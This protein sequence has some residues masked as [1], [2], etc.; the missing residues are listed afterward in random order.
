M[1]EGLTAEKIAVA[2]TAMEA[3]KADIDLFDRIS[4]AR[5]D[6]ERV[7]QFKIDVC[8]GDCKIYILTTWGAE[9]NHYQPRPNWRQ[10][11]T[12]ALD[13]LDDIKPGADTEGTTDKE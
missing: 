5:D 13:E 6:K 2:M 7:E 11:V 1:S 12:D 9:I 10:A 3:M 8:G 4:K